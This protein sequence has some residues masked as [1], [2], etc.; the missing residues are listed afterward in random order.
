MLQAHVFSLREHA[1]PV[2][3]VV[4]EER[5]GTR[6]RLAATLKAVRPSLAGVGD[7]CMNGHFRRMRR[8]GRRFSAR[9]TQGEMT[10]KPAEPTSPRQKSSRHGGMTADKWNQ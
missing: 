10:A 9:R 5:M 8:F 1:A 2:V 4:H 7:L 3:Q 6:S